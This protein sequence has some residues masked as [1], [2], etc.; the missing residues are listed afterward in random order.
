MH[1]YNL[2]T[3]AFKRNAGFNISFK[4]MKCVRSFSRM[5]VLSRNTCSELACTMKPGVMN[6]C[7]DDI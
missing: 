3:A 5:N 2:I 7:S 1:I 6:Y 4:F